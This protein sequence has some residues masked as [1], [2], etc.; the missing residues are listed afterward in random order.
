MMR[1]QFIAPRSTLTKNSNTCLGLKKSFY[2]DLFDLYRAQIDLYKN[3]FVF[4]LTEFIHLDGLCNVMVNVLGY[5][6]NDSRFSS[7]W[8]F[9]TT[10]LVP[11]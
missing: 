11:N 2:T 1:L 5:Q 4:D 10:D 7:Y 6:T 3:F 9:H 8:M